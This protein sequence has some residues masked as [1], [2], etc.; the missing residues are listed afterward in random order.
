[1]TDK[2]GGRA[3]G[4]DSSES[5]AG[6]SSIMSSE[7]VNHN[8]SKNVAVALDTLGGGRNHQHGGH[9]PSTSSCANCKY[10]I[11]LHGTWY[12]AGD[13]CFACLRVLPASTSSASCE[14]YVQP[15]LISLA[16]LS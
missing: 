8:D 12:T 9:G 1:M 13:T 14:I 16:Q 3:D 7:D 10:Y 4:S 15:K 6:A 2:G 5:S 11:V